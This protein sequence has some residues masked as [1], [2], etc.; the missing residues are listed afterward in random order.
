M[1][2]LIH[3][4]LKTATEP[5]PDLVY[6]DSYRCS[7]YLT[8]GL[9]LPC[10]MLRTSATAVELAVSRLERH[11]SGSTT[12]KSCD[13]YSSLVKSFVT[14]GNQVNNYDIAKIEPSKY[15]IPLSILRQIESETSMSW[16]G[17]V[18]EMNDGAL[19]SFGTTYLMEFFDIPDGYYFTDVVAVHN[20]SYVSSCGKLKSLRQGVTKQSDNYNASLVRRERPYFVCYYDPY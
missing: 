9:Y 12:L 20:H 19:F 18:L 16:T 11:Q 10:V 5:I 15:A 1:S 14:T 4:F 3:E 7:V 13:G 6:G 2:K 17:F 8:D